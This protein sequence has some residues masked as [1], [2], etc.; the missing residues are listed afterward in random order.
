MLNLHILIIIA[1]SVWRSVQMILWLLN[2]IYFEKQ[3][4]F[5]H[6]IF[7]ILNLVFVKIENII[8]ELETRDFDIV[9]IFR[10]NCA[11]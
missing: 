6:V 1:M 7:S 9:N 4:H 5:A 8:Y 11:F 2:I 10:L 3:T